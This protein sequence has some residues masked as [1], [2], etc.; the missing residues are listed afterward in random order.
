MESIVK[1]CHHHKLVLLA[2]EVYQENIYFPQEYP[3]HSFRKVWKEMGDA[4][5]DLQLIS[6]HSTSKGFLGEYVIH[7]P[8]KRV[9]VCNKLTFDGGGGGGGG[10]DVVSVEATLK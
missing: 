6:F 4:Y 1:F 7:Q 5:K 3:F 2:D 10:T 9:S 8:S